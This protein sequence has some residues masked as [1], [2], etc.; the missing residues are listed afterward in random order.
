MEPLATEHGR[1]SSSGRSPASLAPPASQGK[2]GE[3]SAAGANAAATAAARAALLRSGLWCVPPGPLEAALLVG[4][5]SDPTL[6]ARRA[7]EAAYAHDALTL[8]ERA[9]RA[10]T[11]ALVASAADQSW[12]TLTGVN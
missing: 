2:A 4:N 8:L 12:A 6:A 1:L 7:V 9:C 5:P 10:G 3:D 11:A